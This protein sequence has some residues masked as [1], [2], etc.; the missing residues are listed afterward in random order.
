MIAENIYS[1]CVSKHYASRYVKF[2]Q[3]YNNTGGKIKHHILPKAK[4]MWP[5][6]E[7][8]EIHTWN[9]CL[10]THRQH[11]LAHWMLWKALG[12]SQARAF[13]FMNGGLENKKSSRLFENL[14]TEH[15]KS[16]TELYKNSD[17]VE[18]PHCKSQVHRMARNT[19]HFDNCKE[20]PN[21]DI[22]R[23]VPQERR[24]R[25][26]A[27]VSKNTGTKASNFQGYTI[28]T[29]ID[30]GEMIILIGK[31]DIIAKGFNPPH[32]TRVIKGE[33]KHHKRFVFVRKTFEELSIIE[34][35][36]LEIK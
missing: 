24:D 12:S 20:N 21:N 33:R 6:Y 22:V 14:R 27:S 5:E 30:T 19:Y 23:T 7:N 36:L 17:Y 11:Y 16:I 34:K 25:I 13:W 31:K 2:I 28:G 15:Y 9:E 29:H 26:S 4:D 10:L 18:C 8:L 1:K 3:K 32:V 35:R